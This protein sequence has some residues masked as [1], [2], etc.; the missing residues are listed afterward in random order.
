MT[1]HCCPKRSFV[2]IVSFILGVVFGPSP[3]TAT[4]PPNL[5]LCCRAENDLYRAM[6]AGGGKFA[7]YDAPGDAVKAAAEGSGVLL[8]ADGYPEKTTAIEL[9]VFEEAARKKLRVYVEYPA[10]LPGVA[11]RSAAGNALGA[12]GD[13]LGRFRSRLGQTPHPGHP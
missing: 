8:L 7:R 10:S 11:G 2:G 5:V 4:P 13:R 1:E 9:A 12:G 6:T 3:L